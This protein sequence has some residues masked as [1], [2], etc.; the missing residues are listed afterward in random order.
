MHAIIKFFNSRN[1]NTDVVEYGEYFRLKL[2]CHSVIRLVERFLLDDYE[3]RTSST[4]ALTMYRY[5]YKIENKSYKVGK[6][7]NFIS[8][9]DNRLKPFTLCRHLGHSRARIL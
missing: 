6:Y 3:E 2:N 5:N 8:L 9:K 7:K 1:S 4:H